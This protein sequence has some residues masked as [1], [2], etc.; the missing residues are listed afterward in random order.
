[1]MREVDFNV[2]AEIFNVKL[3]SPDEVRREAERRRQAAEAMAKAASLQGGGDA[4][5]ADSGAPEPEK[6]PKQAVSRKKLGR[7]QPCWCGSGKKYKHC[8]MRE[9]E[10]AARAAIGS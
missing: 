10:A 4:A 7:N 6:K 8:H 2:L 5:S 3:M 1:M 9:D